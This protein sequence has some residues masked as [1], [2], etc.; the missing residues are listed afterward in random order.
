M[1]SLAE[2][3]PQIA[4]NYAEIPE[5]QEGLIRIAWNYC[6]GDRIR[7]VTEPGIYRNGVLR[8]RVLNAQWQS[9][10]VSMKPEIISKMNR[11]LKKGFILDLKI[12]TH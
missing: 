4:E 6:V 3:F 7:N 12:V 11:Y 9:I 5:V 8:V 10:L 2:L 1:L